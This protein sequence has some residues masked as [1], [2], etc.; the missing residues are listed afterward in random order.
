MCEI[1]GVLTCDQAFRGR[2][3]RGKEKPDINVGLTVFRPLNLRSGSREVKSCAIREKNAN[4]ASIQVCVLCKENL[5]IKY[6][7]CVGT[8]LLFKVTKN[9]ELMGKVSDNCS[10]TVL[11]DFRVERSCDKLVLCRKCARKII[12]CTTL[13]YKIRG[14]FMP[15]N[16]NVNVQD[17]DQEDKEQETSNARKREFDFSPS[18][19]TPSRKKPVNKTWRNTSSN[20]KKS[21]FQHHYNSEKENNIN[22]AISNLMCLPVAENEEKVSTVV[23]V[24]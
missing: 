14:S 4:M 1:E 19:L 9:K 3:G 11:A 18:G 10:P 13:Y 22:D 24:S 21:L 17:K 20:I 16:T 6:S 5:K 23:K 15:E 8:V 2:G 7:S 12:N